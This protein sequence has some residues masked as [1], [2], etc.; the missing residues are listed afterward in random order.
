[1]IYLLIVSLIWAFS[2]GL[3]KGNLVSLD[4][5]FVAFA[6]LLISLLIFLPFLKIKRIGKDSI[7]KLTIIGAIQF[8][9][10][11]ALY[12]YAFQFLE[13][14]EVVLFTILT[15][16]Y[17]NVINDLIKKKFHFIYLLTAILSIFGALIIVNH[18]ITSQNIIYGFL[19]IQF[20]NLCF[21]FGQV[22]YKKVMAE[23][24]NVK[25]RD[26][27]ALPYLGAAGT[28][29]I[30]SLFTIKMENLIITFPQILTLLYLGAIASG[31]GFF[32]W[33][34]GVRKANIGTVAIFNNLKIPL[35]IL[36][37]ILFFGEKVQIQNLIIG[38]LILITA[39]VI[40]EYQFNKRVL[41]TND[42]R[43]K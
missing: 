33:N 8:G 43:E 38:G 20:S 26:I 10:M 42:E 29:L 6:R 4:S 11:Y 27:F 13:A 35:G 30:I 36:V 34:Y 2:F 24:D 16:I 15:P 1:M 32:L 40:N 5:N 14:Y 9:I 39:L 41:Y 12:I 37:S 21:A 28:T 19:L 25:D 18:E 22:Y 31:L 23:L 17:I 3:I 7:I